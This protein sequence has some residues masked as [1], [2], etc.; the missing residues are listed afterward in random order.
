M[1]KMT[2]RNITIFFAL[3]L[4]AGCKTFFEEDISNQTVT[5]LS[6]GSGT[7]TE[8][9]SQTFW[10]EKVEGA[11]DYRLQVVTPSFESTETLILDTLISAD[12]FTFTLYPSVYEWRVRAENSAWQT[13]WTKGQLQIYSTLDLTRQKVNLLSP[14]LIINTKSIRFQ[15]DGVTNAKSYSIVAYKDQWDGI[16]AVTS[17]KVDT[18]FFENEL[19]D[20]KYVWGVKAK[21]SISETLYSQKTLIVDTTPPTVPDLSSP[22]DSSAFTNTKVSF[23][24]SSSDLTS[25]ISQDTLKVFSD[26]SLTNLIKSVATD[27]K[28]AEITF[29]NHAIY[30]WTVQSVDKAGNAGK[31][32]DSFLFTIN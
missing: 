16:S 10:W 29:T 28:A 30:Y 18:T 26:K 15:W 14:G 24:W 27:S 32:S 8:I 20:G 1:R 17:T 25:G 9:A 6:P 5:L 4:I 11:S 19:N 2:I 3:V 13:Q 22:S 31:T 23:T 7:E 21:N 12:K